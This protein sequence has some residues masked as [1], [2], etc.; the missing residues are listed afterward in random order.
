MESCVV[1]NIVWGTIFNQFIYSKKCIIWLYN[2]IRNFDRRKNWVWVLV[3]IRIQFS[4]LFHEKTTHSW[5]GSTAYRVT[6]LKSL[7]TITDFNFF[8]NYIHCWVYIL[9]SFSVI[10]FCPNITR[11]KLTKYEI[12][13]LKKM[14]QRRCSDWI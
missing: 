9:S 1:N 13:L 4:Y 11:T 2:N 3:Y 12:I 10:S 14:S 5:S 7:Y 6:D 8:P